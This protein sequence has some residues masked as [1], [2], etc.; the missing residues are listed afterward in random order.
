MGTTHSAGGGGTVYRADVRLAALPASPKSEG[1]WQGE[2]PKG[3]DKI[4]TL[5]LALALQGGRGEV[6]APHPFP[7]Q[8]QERN[9]KFSCFQLAS[10]S[11]SPP[12]SSD[13]ESR[14]PGE[15]GVQGRLAAGP[16]A[17]NPSKPQDLPCPPWSPRLR[18]VPLSSS[19]RTDPTSLEKP[20]GGPRGLWEGSQ[21]AEA[22]L[23]FSH[24]P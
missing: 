11:S 7:A 8:P 19:L 16:G 14:Q 18:T 21:Q 10:P 22:N 9:A 2:A 20:G 6:A 13:R 4:S 12:H 23:G 1:A 24:H 15:W 3:L 17:K 5:P